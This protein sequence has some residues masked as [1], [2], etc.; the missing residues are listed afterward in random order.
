[1]VKRIKNYL[2][3]RKYV[4]LFCFLFFLIR[5]PYLSQINLLHDERDIVLSGY[6][7]AKSGTDLYGNSMPMV[8]D[9]ISPKN[10][11]VAIYFSAL[12][13]LFLPIKTI[14]FARLPFVFI[15]SFILLLTYEIILLLTKNKKNSLITALIFCFSPW[16]YHLTRLAMDINLAFVLLLMGMLSYFNKRRFVS[17]LFFTLACYTY[18]GFRVLVPFLIFYLELFFIIQKRKIQK[19]HVLI[20]ILFVF[21]LIASFF[22]VDRTITMGRI[23][24][25]TISF[26]NEQ[27]VKDVNFK[28]MTSVAPPR[29]QGLF[30][31]KITSAIDVVITNIYK[32]YAPMYLFKD[33]DYSAIN[34]NTA[35]GQFFMP[36]IIFYLFGLYYI[37]SVRKSSDIYIAGFTLIGLVP[38]LVSVVSA[39]YSI[40]AVLTGVGFAYIMSLGLGYCFHL[41]TS[42]S[43]R[44]KRIIKIVFLFLLAINMCYFGYNYFFRRPIT[45]GELYNEQERQLAQFLLQHGDKQFTVYHTYPNEAYSSFV[46]FNNDIDVKQ[47]RV[48]STNLKT[49]IA[50]NVTFKN[51]NLD[52]S[53]TTKKHVVIFEGCLNDIKYQR[54][55][56]LKEIPYQI[57]YTDIS[58][59]AAYF[60]FE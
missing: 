46:F 11:V 59:K 34:G 10:P 18:L 58:N 2:Q 15:S 39:T 44:N 49:Q 31:N 42:V 57:P 60:I 13:W 52:K 41:S 3:S 48:D 24:N 27:I 17:Y 16:M 36:F 30:H 45:V 6:S 19:K 37:A 25:E 28:R 12:A 21:L 47:V 4:L 22:M 33:G 23:Q 14:F 5:L 56:N 55:P 26:K 20:N 38:S 53:F 1:M 51:C 40:R 8:F 29:I 7:I 43:S 50:N 54:D 35:A 32:G 9:G